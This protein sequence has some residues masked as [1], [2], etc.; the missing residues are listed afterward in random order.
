MI[1][2][3]HLGGDHRL[4]PSDMS[5][6]KLWIFSD[7]DSINLIFEANVS[8]I[9]KPGPG[10][11]SPVAKNNDAKPEPLRF[12]ANI[13]DQTFELTTGTTDVEEPTSEEGTN[14]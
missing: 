12:Y 11:P 4:D 8:A 9:I 10:A 2:A 13:K 3:I 6:F 7:P 5:T 1:I 14:S